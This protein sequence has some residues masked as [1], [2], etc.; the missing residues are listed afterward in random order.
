MLNDQSWRDLSQ[1]A[2]SRKDSSI[3][4]LFDAGDRAARF[5]ARLPYKDCETSSQMLF[6]FSKTLIDDEVMALLL[7][8]AE[9]SGLAARREAM[10]TGARINETE[11]RAVL[12]TMLRGT[13]DPALPKADIAAMEATRTRMAALCEAVRSGAYSGPGGRFTDI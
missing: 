1:A 6:D 10:F 5:S 11:G 8:M 7:R 2:L 3:Q 12:H 9:D 4:A 13:P